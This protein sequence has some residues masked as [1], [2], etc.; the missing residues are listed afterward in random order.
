[1]TD[2]VRKTFGAREYYDI[3]AQAVETRETQHVAFVFEPEVAVTTHA[4]EEQ[5]ST[6][7]TMVRAMTPEDAANLTSLLEERWKSEADEAPSYVLKF[8]GP[9]PSNAFLDTCYYDTMAAVLAKRG[10]V[11]ENAKRNEK[12]EVAFSFQPRVDPSHNATVA[13]VSQRWAMIKGMR[14]KDE[15]DLN[16]LLASE[17]ITYVSSC[18]QHMQASLPSMP[19]SEYVDTI[20]Y[21]SMRKLLAKRS[22]S[23][24]ESTSGSIVVPVVPRPH[25]IVV[26][27]DLPAP[28]V[29]QC[30]QAMISSPRTSSTTSKTKQRS[31]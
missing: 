15:E 21:D 28:A 31:G 16:A 17:W 2:N 7:R 19:P 18:P 22:S 24:A 13:E 12:A 5:V 26:N 25:S 10:W 30:M 6:R 8:M 11:A 29:P 1:M 27:S 4:T 9:R 23:F 20:Y 3:L 14:P